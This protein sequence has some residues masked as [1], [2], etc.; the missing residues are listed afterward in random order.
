M[1]EKKKQLKIYISTFYILV[2]GGDNET[3][4]QFDSTIY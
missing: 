3:A 1:M 4:K 2:E